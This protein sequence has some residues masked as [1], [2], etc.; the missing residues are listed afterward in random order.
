MSGL[1]VPESGKAIEGCPDLLERVRSKPVTKA[2][3]RFCHVSS[4][5]EEAP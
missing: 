1:F 4:R 3:P 2:V 5:I